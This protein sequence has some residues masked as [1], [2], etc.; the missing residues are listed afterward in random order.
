[1][2]ATQPTRLPLGHFVDHVDGVGSLFVFLF[3]RVHGVDAQ[4][5][6]TPARLR[7]AAFADRHRRGSGLVEMQ[8]VPPV[9]GSFAQVVEV[10]HRQLGEALKFLAAIDSELAFEDAASS[11]P[12][13]AL[14]NAVDTRE[15]NESWS[16]RS[17]EGQRFVY[18]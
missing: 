14:M 11:R 5:S 12:G 15:E 16:K 17:L 18:L 10:S 2:R 8:A 9:D 1:M 4:V 13:K 6:R 7:L 3:G